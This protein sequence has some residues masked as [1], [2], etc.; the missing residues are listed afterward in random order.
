M[1]LKLLSTLWA[2][3][4]HLWWWRHRD[5]PQ[6]ITSVQVSCGN[7]P[8]RRP[9]SRRWPNRCAT[10]AAVKEIKGSTWEMEREMCSCCPWLASNWALTCEDMYICCVSKAIFLTSTG[11]LAPI[12]LLFSACAV[13]ASRWGR[14]TKRKPARKHWP[15]ISTD[16]DRAKLWACVGWGYAWEAVTA[17]C[18]ETQFN[19]M[20]K[21]WNS[22]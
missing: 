1:C 8:H 15:W 18:V 16:R 4:T 21:I 6:W 22:L 17:F 20:R 10:P 12:C 3:H 13:A 7:I 9:Q 11:V 5:P 14:Q 2:S 19:D